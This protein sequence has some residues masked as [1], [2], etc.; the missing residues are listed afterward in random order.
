MSNITITIEFED[1][2]WNE[3]AVTEAMPQLAEDAGETWYSWSEPCIDR[4]GEEYEPDDREL[5]CR[6]RDIV[7]VL[8][9]ANIA[10]A[11]VTVKTS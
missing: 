11:S 9:D 1:S 3:E 8:Q 7:R 4:D 5:A 2:S 10:Y 6:R